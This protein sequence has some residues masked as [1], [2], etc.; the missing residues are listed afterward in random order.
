MERSLFRPAI[1]RASQIF[2]TSLLSSST[3]ARI[4]GS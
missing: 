2:K 3:K 4:V 1:E